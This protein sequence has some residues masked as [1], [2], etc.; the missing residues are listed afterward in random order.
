MIKRY[1]LTVVSV[2]VALGIT[3]SL[4]RYTT[5]RTPLFYIA[6]IISAWFGGMGPGLLA[7]VLSTLA[8]D[9]Y[10]APG[11]QT[12]VLSIDSWPFVLLFLLSALLACWITVQ[13]RKAEKALKEARDELEA[14]VEERTA[15][16]RRASEGLQAEIA[17]R[18]RGEEA[19]R[20]RANLLDLTHDTV[21]VRDINDVITFWNRG[22]E[23]LYGW[24]R[25]EAVGQV[26]HHLMQTIFTAPLEEIMAEL[27]STG[28]WEGELIHTRRDG[29][30]VV[31]MS[32]WALQSDE[33]GRPITVLET[34]NDITERKR[35]KDELKKTK[36][37]LSTVIAN[38]PIIMFA[39]DRSGVFI[40]SEGRGL[41]ALGLKPGQVLG[42]S[43]FDVY[44]DLPQVLSNVRRA[45]GG[46]PFAELVE[47][48]D[49]VFETHY[50]PFLDERG[51]LAGVNGVAINITERRRAEE[52]LRESERRYRHIFQGAGVSI[53][54]EDFSQVKAAIDNLKARGVLDFRQYLAA[55]PEFIRQAIP[56][57]QV[58]D[59]NDAT[60]RLFEAQSKDQLLVSLDRIFL[61][62]SEE[63][64]AGE[65]IAIAE[66]RISFESETIL[67]T[68]KGE[69][70]TVLFTITF[71]SQPAKFDSV[72]VSIMDISERKRAERELWQ[73]QLE[74][75][76]VE[77]SA[78]LGKMTGAIAHELGTPLNS[79]LGYTQLLAA[80][81]LPET[82]R[83]RL[84]VIETQIH[85]M[86]DVIQHYLSHSR[87]SA[88]Q[89]R[90]HVNDLI[91]E[92]LLLLQPIFQQHGMVVTTVLAESPPALFGDAVSLQRVL[93]NLIDNAVDASAGRGRIDV[94]DRGQPG[95]SR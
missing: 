56:M 3:N 31:V 27:N 92:T 46:E 16:L 10:F 89:T 23:E 55:H 47:V 85:R 41:D 4:E 29:T 14:R 75:G 1:G 78:A 39:L 21:F 49:L 88:R 76:R 77:R 37:I 68:L 52:E 70:L 33:R 72:L 69:K 90:I 18:K 28:R 57:V 35:A 11:G 6:I 12:S 65:L 74:M 81:D 80:D 48:N 63:V 43:I 93:I 50:I 26:S 53:W 20:E 15:D 5:L 86:V 9:Y 7:V 84:A 17:E 67:Q 19:L 34:N 83:R 61:P 95:F 66:G 59:V 64:F 36:Q 45:L 71:P 54:Q 82:A 24:T 38:A 22:A 60:I 2:A 51:E 91:R 32:R 79:V 42:Q 87:G 8:V 44:R 13:R 73:L 25:D 40:L 30:Q 58:I 94:E 62:E